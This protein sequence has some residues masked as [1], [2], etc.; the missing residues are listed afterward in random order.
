MLLPPIAALW[1][2][3]APLKNVYPRPDNLTH[4]PQ[5]YT[6]TVLLFHQPLLMLCYSSCLCVPFPPYG[7]IFFAFHLVSSARCPAG[8]HFFLQPKTTQIKTKDVDMK[9][10]IVLNKHM[11]AEQSLQR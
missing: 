7:G 11:T 4:A 8:C 9:T 5:F 2:N 10:T 1:I 6:I 3:A